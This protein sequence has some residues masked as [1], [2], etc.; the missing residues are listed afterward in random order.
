MNFVKEYKA[1]FIRAGVTASTLY[2]I[3]NHGVITVT[4]TKR[5]NNKIIDQRT[6]IFSAENY[7]NV[8]SSI[9][10]FKD[11]ISKSYT[12][13]GLIATNFTANNPYT[14]ETITRVFS[15]DYV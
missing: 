1:H 7:G 13:F 2:L 5:N 9:G 3:K 8:I 10:V 14:N 11:R 4:Y 6:E 12:P 15:F